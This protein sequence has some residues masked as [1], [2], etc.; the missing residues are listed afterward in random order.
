MLEYINPV[1]TVV[2]CSKYNTYG[3]PAPA[4]MERLKNA[5]SAILTTPESGAVLVSVRKD[6]MSVSEYGK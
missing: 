5:G 4:T 2:S 1:L 3:H 6:N